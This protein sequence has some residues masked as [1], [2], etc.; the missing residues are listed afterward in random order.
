MSINESATSGMTAKAMR[1][2]LKGLDVISLSHGEPDFKTPKY[3]C[4]AA[5]E[6]IDSG[7]YFSYPPTAGYHDLREAIANKYSSE[8]NVP[9]KSENIVVSNGAKQAL[10][11]AMLSI[12]NPEDEVVILAP[13]WVSYIAQVK[14]ADAK[15]II[16]KG[17]LENGFKVSIERI[18]NAIT[19]NTKAIV[20]SSP[21]NPTGLVYTK[22]ELEKLAKLVSNYPNLLVISDEIYEYINYTPNRVSFA[23]I[24]G[25]FERTITVNGF[26]KCYAMTGWRVGY[27]A[28]PSWIAK[29][30]IKIQ[31]HL[32]SSNSS[33][34]QRA[35]FSAIKGNL[36]SVNNM[37]KK[38]QERRDF[39]YSQ[40]K[41]ISGIKVSLP[42][43]AFYFF[44]D[45]SHYYGMSY[46]EN[47]INN[48]TD[49]CEYLLDVA[50]IAL[51]PGIAFGD[52][53]CVRISYASPKP[54]LLEAL[55]RL[56]TALDNLT[57]EK[58][59]VILSN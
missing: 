40:L 39:V 46:K 28:A 33:I 52:D 3:I 34:A 5:K 29:E 6:A 32:S 1:L 38:Y 50:H 48:S 15:P 19:E 17:E 59:K 24:P 58:P 20:F 53:S 35:A 25:M 54:E 30:V 44:L 41:E 2:K 11:N 26:S 55:K 57:V 21:C 23:S 7:K 37:V 10:S 4:E 8:N 16:I 45:I 9:C 22:K 47:Q 42:N 51:V 27:L 14:L 12:L 49:M 43:G 56:K 31:G 18:K 36:D 13:F